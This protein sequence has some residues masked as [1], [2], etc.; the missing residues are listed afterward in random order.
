MAVISQT[1]GREGAGNFQE[2]F[3]EGTLKACR[4]SA[5]AGVTI[6]RPI[7][8]VGPDGELKPMINATTAAGID[9]SN[10][11]IKT[12]SIGIGDRDRYSGFS[13]SAD[14]FD[15][16]EP[17]MVFPKLYIRLRYLQKNN[18]LGGM[19]D[20]VARILIPNDTDSPLRQSKQFTII[21][22]IVLHFN[23]QALEKPRTREAVFLTKTAA[24][25]LSETLE[26]AHAEGID[27]FSP[28]GGR[29]VVLTPEAQRGS[30]INLFNATLGDA[31][32]LDP[33]QCRKLWVPWDDALRFLP[34]STQLAKAV[35]CFGR[36]I[37]ELVF[38]P[39]EVR[40]ACIEH[41]LESPSP[42]PSVSAAAVDN[43]P[44]PPAAPP[45]NPTS[46][47]NGG[48]GAPATLQ[49]DT[50][51]KDE[52]LLGEDD[53]ASAASTETTHT[54]TPPTGAAPADAAPPSQDAMASKY[55]ELLGGDL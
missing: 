12:V 25:A 44:P 9:V 45:T 32:R 20:R 50:E 16:R 38:D 24:Q 6:I 34:H 14:R 35:R 19:T 13:E 39:D 18:K 29:A 47:G 27:V 37:V 3:K 11:I 51:F 8:E 7:P 53:G 33:E 42:S 26:A 2:C 31:I 15:E 21:Q 22:A 52:P 40:S 41:G 54:D 23:G 5:N 4:P 17:D 1:G 55:Q 30:G 28:E 48:G 36:E 46:D 10:A 49:L 43:T